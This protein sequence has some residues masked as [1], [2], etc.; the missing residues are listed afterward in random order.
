MDEP[1]GFRVWRGEGEGTAVEEVMGC[2]CCTCTCTG[3]ARR[4]G[5]ARGGICGPYLLYLYRSG[6]EKGGGPGRS[7][8]PLL[9]I[10][11]EVWQGVERGVVTSH[12][13]DNRRGRRNYG[14]VVKLGH[15][16]IGAFQ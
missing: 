15:L 3:L 4:R 13:A 8:R 1:G 7:G 6:K 14:R 5:G 2:T 9:V 16:K 12:A 11:V 10:L